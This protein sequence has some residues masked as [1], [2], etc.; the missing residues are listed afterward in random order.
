MSTGS[1]HTGGSGSCVSVSKCSK[2]VCRLRLSP[3]AQPPASPRPTMP[4]DPRRI[5]D[6][7]T[8]GVTAA[9][10]A[11][12]PGAR[13][14]IARSSSALRLARLR[15]AQRSPE[16]PAMMAIGSVLAGVAARVTR[17]RAK[18]DPPWGWR[19][20]GAEDARLSL[21]Y[22]YRMATEVAR[23]PASTSA[24][25]VLLPPA[26]GLRPDQSEMT[27]SPTWSYC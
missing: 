20:T 1:H 26:A 9:K 16:A 18:R 11:G 25:A 10:G 8:R 12:R 5:P 19:S 6:P 23:A 2:C 22:V 21:R 4:Q 13:P 15:K 14:G 27:V 7:T 17:G 3:S 24:V